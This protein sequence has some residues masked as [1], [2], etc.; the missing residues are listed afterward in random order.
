MA[1]SRKTTATPSRPSGPAWSPWEA[2]V[3]TLTLA[4]GQIEAAL[5]DGDEPVNVLTATF[6]AMAGYMAQINGTL[7]KL[8]DSPALG[9]I[10]ADLAQQ[11]QEMEGMVQRAV[12]AFQFYDKLAQR[13]AHV[14]L[15]LEALADLVGDPLRLTRPPEWTALQ[16]R[17]RAQYSTREEVDMFEAVMAG[18]SPKA[19]LAREPGPGPEA[20]G[21][22]E[23]F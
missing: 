21:D 14:G 2:A 4:A 9:R 1:P 5:K 12:V 10:R 16:A 13:L 3:G 19:V 6:T 23:L 18:V 7:E 11:A 17:I 20:G 15:G 22:I 8:P